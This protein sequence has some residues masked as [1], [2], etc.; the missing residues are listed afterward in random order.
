VNSDSLSLSNYVSEVN[1]FV[2]ATSLLPNGNLGILEVR[3]FNPE[4][5]GIFGEFLHL[6]VNFS[7]RDSCV[8]NYQVLATHICPF[9]NRRL[10]LN[11]RHCCPYFDTWCYRHSRSWT[12]IVVT[13]FVVEYPEIKG[14][15]FVRPH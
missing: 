6:G 9:H 5:T 4:R 14:P 8:P 7:G 10:R 3:I 11:G 1:T 15:S 12:P 13:V 2:T